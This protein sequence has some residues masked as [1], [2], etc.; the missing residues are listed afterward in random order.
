METV[1]MRSYGLIQ[2][3]ESTIHRRLREHYDHLW[4]QAQGKIRSGQIDLDP[5]LQAREPDQ[6]RGLTVIAQP[7]PAVQQAVASF[8]RALR[9]LEPDQYYYTPSEFHLTV[10]SLFTATIE[11]LRP[12][13][14]RRSAILLRWMQR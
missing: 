2:L 7:S 12:F 3:S 13:S 1:E 14:R 11:V 9:R 10:L 6:R 8:L 5:V 4:C